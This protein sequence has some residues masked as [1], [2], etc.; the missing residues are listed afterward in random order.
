[1][2][3]QPGWYQDPSAPGKLRYWDGAAWTEQTVAGPIA[4]AANT[5]RST[6]LQSVYDSTSIMP[7]QYSAP[8]YATPPAGFGNDFSRQDP[9]PNVQAMSFGQAISSCMNKFAVGKGRASRSEY[10]WFYLFSFLVYIAVNI[11][12]AMLAYSSTGVS[13]G[14]VLV[15]GVAIAL[16]IPSVACTVRR[17]HDSD[18]SAHHLWFFIIPFAGLI[19]FIIFM[20]APSTPASN[21]YGPPV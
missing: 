15:L 8:Q 21:R 18:K 11:L 13:I 20:C 16:A 1:M 17:L 7:T 19:F 6:P 14:A 12:Q 10:W 2:A 3:P 9:V 5:P 4:Q